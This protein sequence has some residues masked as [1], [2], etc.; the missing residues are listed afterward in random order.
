MSSAVGPVVA[1]AMCREFW[2]VGG[3]ISAGMNDEKETAEGARHFPNGLR[4]VDLTWL[5]DEPPAEVPER[6][7]ALCA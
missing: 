2:M 1:I 5:G 6:V 7:L 3:R 4:I